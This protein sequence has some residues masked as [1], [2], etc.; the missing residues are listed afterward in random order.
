MRITSDVVDIAVSPERLFAF[1][2]NPDHVKDWQTDLLEYEFLTEGGI[3]PGATIRAV[4][5]QPG[6]GRVEA[7][8]TVL[9]VT[10]PERLVYHAEERTSSVDFE[11]LLSRNER[12]A[13]LVV[14]MDVSLKGLLRLF[15]ALAR[16]MIR[17]KLN[18]LVLVLRDV[19]EAKA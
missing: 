8:L 9:T 5:M 6:R 4:M 13:R 7:V 3:R 12:G 11:Y 15:A 19:A 1:V 14:T 10:A 16:P 2:T 18:S 17:R